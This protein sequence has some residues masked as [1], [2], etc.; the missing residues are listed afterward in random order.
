MQTEYFPFIQRPTFNV[1]KT[2][3]PVTLALVSIGVCYSDREGAHEFA[4]ALAELNRRLLLF[5]ACSTL[6]NPLMR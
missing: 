3:L 5:M 4:T 1:N 6:L 2:S